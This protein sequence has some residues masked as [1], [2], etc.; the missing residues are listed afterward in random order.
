M[1][2]GQYELTTLYYQER[3]RQDQEWYTQWE[4]ENPDAEWHETVLRR[5][6]RRLLRAA[7]PQARLVGDTRHAHAI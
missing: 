7:Q 3:R 2:V 5:I 6:V 1:N 4:R